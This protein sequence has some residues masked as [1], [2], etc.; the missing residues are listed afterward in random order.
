MEEDKST[1]PVP[2]P[3][4][5]DAVNDDRPD[6]YDEE[7]KA[8]MR[9]GFRVSPELCDKVVDIDPELVVGIKKP[10]GSSEL[11]TPSAERGEDAT[12]D[13]S[14]GVPKVSINAL[15]EA[16]GTPVEPGDVIV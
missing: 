2:S 10:S 5:D 13:Q 9:R 7:T 16:F 4:R 11:V 1:T 8:L 3:A 14:S 6:G 15:R 12:L